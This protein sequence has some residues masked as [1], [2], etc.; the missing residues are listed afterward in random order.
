MAFREMEH[1]GGE[2]ITATFANENAVTVTAGNVTAIYCNKQTT[3][4]NL[5]DYELMGLV[6][7]SFPSNM[8]Y[9]SVNR[10]YADG[11]SSFIRVRNDS[12]ASPSIS[13]A[14]AQMRIRYKKK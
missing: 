3:N 5:S 7:F 2:Y 12:N 1:D 11:T 13:A 9:V 8:A 14:G 10:L 4:Y 6:D